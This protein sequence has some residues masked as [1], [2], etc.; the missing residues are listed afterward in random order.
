MISRFKPLAFLLS[1]VTLVAG[2]A[3]GPSFTTSG[4]TDTA[5]EIAAKGHLTRR[6]IPASPF[7]LASWQ[8]ITDPAAPVNVYIE[9]DGL[10]W[11]SRSS[12]SL[13][14]TP[15][16]PT[17]LSLAALDPAANVVYI[18]RPCQYSE[19]GAPG[20][21]CPDI[22]WRGQRF[23]P[24]VVQSYIT[25]LNGIAT[26][27]SGGFNLIGYSGGANI[28]GLV[29][30]RRSDV[31]SLRTV[32]GNIDNDAFTNL[33]NVSAMPGSLNMAYEAQ[34]LAAL[35]QMHFIGA[36]DENVPEAIF[37]SYVSKAGPSSCIHSK[38]LPGGSHTEGWE[39]QWPVLLS[40]PVICE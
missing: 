21:A 17:A 8:R 23:A 31:L 20:N 40:L 16:H 2:C 22:Y 33:H 11:L 6:D 18:A 37:T 12:P 9:G 24:E 29:A 38:I 27:S 7:I 36:Q 19:I 32:A 28:A 10:A 5:Q 34:K 39:A 26:Q 30:A 15:K 25:A 1:G 3:G 13:N 14:P 4:R 35:P